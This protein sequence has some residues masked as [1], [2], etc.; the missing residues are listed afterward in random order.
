MKEINEKLINDKLSELDREINGD[1]QTEIIADTY[2]KTQAGKEWY[3][4]QIASL[5]LNSKPIRLKEFL[6]EITKY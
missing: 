4:K 3:Y 1:E 5:R 2:I 6:A